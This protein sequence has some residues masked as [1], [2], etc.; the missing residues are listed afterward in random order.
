MGSRAQT[1]GRSAG[2]LIGS[3]MQAARSPMSLPFQ[4]V[5]I[6]AEARSYK[7]RQRG[8]E[9]GGHNQPKSGS[10]EAARAE[11]EVIAAVADERERCLLHLCSHLRADR[12]ALAQLQTAMDIAVMRQGE[13]V[14]YGTAEQVLLRP[15]N[16]YTQALLAAAPGATQL[17]AAGPP[18]RLI[19]PAAH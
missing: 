8:A 14:E 15:Q 18:L 4:T 2:A 11:H 13:V 12:D 7:L 17:P 1:A 9:D 3:M 19:R 5:D 6:E 10:E 16:S